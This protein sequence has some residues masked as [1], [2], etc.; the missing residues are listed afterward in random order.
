MQRP[1]LTER[2][3]AADRKKLATIIAKLEVLAATAPANRGLID[4]A[5]SRLIKVEAEAFHN[6]KT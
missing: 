3:T 2:W 4:E 6:A 5:L 1:R